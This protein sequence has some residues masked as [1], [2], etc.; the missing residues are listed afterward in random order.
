MNFIDNFK[1]SYL[2]FV[3]IHHLILFHDI[4]FCM[5]SVSLSLLFYSYLPS[6]LKWNF[7]SLIIDFLLSNVN[8]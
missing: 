3:F 4:D 1:D 2:G 8:F 5:I 6:F 7:M